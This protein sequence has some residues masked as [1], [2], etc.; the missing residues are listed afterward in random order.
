[1]DAIPVSPHPVARLEE[2]LLLIQRILREA[3][4][5]V[6]RRGWLLEQCRRRGDDERDL[7]QALA[8]YRHTCAA[9]LL[10]GT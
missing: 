4:P 5:P 7:W 9:G 10:T 8:R 1:M 3:A 2:H 6:R